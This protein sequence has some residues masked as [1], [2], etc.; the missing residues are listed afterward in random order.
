LIKKGTK[1]TP[2]HLGL[3]AAQGLATVDVGSRPS[4]AVI[5][6][7]SELLK[8]G[9]ELLPG[10]VYESNSVAMVAKAQ[11]LGVERP[12][13][14]SVA[15]DEGAL[16]EAFLQACEEADTVVF[17]GGASV[18][19]KDLVRRVCLS[20]GVEE[21]FWRINMKP[22][23]PVFFGRRGSVL[24]FAL[25]GNPVSALVTFFLLVEPAVRQMSGAGEARHDRSRA[26][27]GS[28]L[29]RVPGR[30]EFVRGVLHGGTVTPLGKQG[31][32]MASGLAMA[33][34]LILVSP[35]VECLNAGCEVEV[36]RL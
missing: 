24:V 26:V 8:A 4:M 19:E 2:E 20:C 30:L 9:D 33:D 14:R 29:Q 7:G 12:T 10:R 35:E 17:S 22:G 6:T 18:G 13:V 5:V 34:S 21:V 15:D 32:H 3:I 28:D 1:L 25:P 11:T 36:V 27:L 16:R 23:K 31:S